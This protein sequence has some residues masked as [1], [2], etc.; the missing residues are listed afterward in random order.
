VSTFLPLPALMALVPLTERV[1]I[2]VSSRAMPV[3]RV[4]G[5]VPRHGQPG[6][7]DSPASSRVLASHVPDPVGPVSWSASHPGRAHALVLASRLLSAHGRP[8]HSSWSVPRPGWPGLAS[9]LGRPESWSAPRRDWSSVL[10]ILGRS[11]SSSVPRRDR[12]S[13]PVSPASVPSWSVPRIL[14]VTPS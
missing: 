14:A 1:H 12:S 7:L 6:V 10:A 13:V 9:I 11:E 2:L 4:S 8:R 3:S 5:I